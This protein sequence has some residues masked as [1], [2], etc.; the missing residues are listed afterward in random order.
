MDRTVIF[1]DGENLRYSFID[2]FP[3]EKIIYLPRRIKWTE[4]FNFI[5]PKNHYLIRIYWYVV[6]HLDFRP[7]K[8]PNE[9]EIQ[10]LEQILMK[11]KNEREKIINL[12]NKDDYILQKREE[13]IHQQAKIIKRFEGWRKIQDSLCSKFENIE[14]RRAGSIKYN[15]ISNSFGKEKGVDVKL[16]TD[17]LCFSF[18]NIFDKAIIISGDQDYIPAIQACKDLGKQVYIVNF[19]DQNNNYLPG[20][21]YKLRVICDKI[22]TLKYDD[23]RRFIEKF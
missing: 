22:I 2:L 19:R 1:V 3:E 14:F 15:L 8:I 11:N 21:S 18:R 5:L 12:T 6:E 17:L 16:A 7:Y 23:I 20:S 10:N 4:L 13:L 9:N